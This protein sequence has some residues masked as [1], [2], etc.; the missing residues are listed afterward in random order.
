MQGA[1]VPTNPLQF[2]CDGS[3][4]HGSIWICCCVGRYTPSAVKITAICSLLFKLGW[5][6]LKFI[7][8]ET[9]E[10]VSLTTLYSGNAKVQEGQCWS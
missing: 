8:E 3:I 7:V 10:L 4:C 2:C 6:F 1:E 9:G 5:F